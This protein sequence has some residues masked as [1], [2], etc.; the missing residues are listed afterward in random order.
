MVICIPAQAAEPLLA[1]LRRWLT[2]GQLPADSAEH[3]F[4]AEGRGGCSVRTVTCADS[5][6]TC[7]MRSNEQAEP[8]LPA[9]L[10]GTSAPGWNRQSRRTGDLAIQ[11]SWLFWLEDASAGWAICLSCALH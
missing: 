5:L 2:L 4:I 7:S 9:R 6:A 3:F 1:A 8:F 11:P 10:L